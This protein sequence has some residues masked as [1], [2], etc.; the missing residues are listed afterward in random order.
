LLFSLPKNKNIRKTI[1]NV[2]GVYLTTTILLVLTIGIISLNNQKQHSFNL[3]QKQIN[4]QSRYII[5][6]LE[7]LQE[8]IVNEIAIYPQIDNLQSGIYDVDKNLIFST[9]KQKIVPLNKTYFQKG[10]YFYFQYLVEPHYLG[11]KY[12]VIQIPKLVIFQNIETKAFTIIF[13]VILFLIFTSFMLAN[14]LIKPLSNNFILLDK[15]IKDTTHE[16]NTPVSAILNNIEML[17]LSTMDDKNMKKINRIKIGATT[18]STI[19]TDLSFLLL[20]NK[21]ISNNIEIELSK[22]IVQRVEYFKI[23][24]KNKKII[25]NVDIQNEIYFTIDKQ[26][27]ERL[28]DNLISNSIKYSYPNS[29]INITIKDD[30]FIIQDYGIGMEEDEVKDIF[31]RYKRFDTSVGGFG[32]GY[33]II[34]SIIKEY[35]IKI[36]ISSK[37]K[38]GTTVTLHWGKN[39]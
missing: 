16:L 12:L 30:L 1:F 38:E 19:Y 32:I 8:N 3:A 13:L 14:I 35:D 39:V 11:A 26:K 10:K 36:D 33:D 28:V 5:E 37:K 9:Y 34:Y 6:Q 17:D 25:F 27:L 23:L 24:A 20:N 7:T 21:T 31:I 29:T 4:I 15:F 2:V 18:I 22:V